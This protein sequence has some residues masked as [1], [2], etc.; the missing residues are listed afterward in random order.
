VKKDNNLLI[1]CHDYFEF[2]FFPL[3]NI[4][5]CINNEE[6]MY[7]KGTLIFIRPDDCHDILN[8]QLKQLDYFH[9]AFT[10]NLAHSVF[11]FLTKEFESDK[12]L[13]C[14]EPPY[15]VLNEIESEELANKLSSLYSINPVNRGKRIAYIRYLL[16]HMFVN[17]FSGEHFTVDAGIPAWL[18]NSCRE[19]TKLD[20]FSIGLTRMVEISGKTQEHLTRAMTKY[21]SIAPST[22]I[23]NQRLTYIA[24]GLISSNDSIQNLSF[25]S[26]FLN[27]TYMNALFKKKYAISPSM[28]RNRKTYTENL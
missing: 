2:Q 13:S 28:F 19:M 25:R 23:N 12:L 7:P 4:T 14:S 17:Y 11:G 27:V 8:T 21:M 9:L 1:H 5:M 16:T 15:L 6:R 3:H 10:Q 24:N 26:G 20:N 22:F 18:S